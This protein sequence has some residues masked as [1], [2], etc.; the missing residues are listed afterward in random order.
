MNSEAYILRNSRTCDHGS[1]GTASGDCQTATDYYY[2]GV[3]V[4]GGAGGARGG[5]FGG[6]TAWD[7]WK[8]YLA[9]ARAAAVELTNKGHDAHR[10]RIIHFATR[11]RHRT[12]HCGLLRGLVEQN[13]HTN[14]SPPTGPS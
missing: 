11:P 3:N 5:V 1:I 4:R 7:S 14:F 2:S 13:M 9:R 6:Q 12:A 8:Q 10:A